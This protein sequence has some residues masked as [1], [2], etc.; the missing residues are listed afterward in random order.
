MTV[1]NRKRYYQPSQVRRLSQEWKEARKKKD[2]SEVERLKKAI[3]TEYIQ[4]GEIHKMGEKPDDDLAEW[5][6]QKALDI[7]PG[8]PIANY[9]LA[10]LMFKKEYYAEA[11]F[12]FE[13]ALSSFSD[14]RL[15]NTQ[16]IIAN[17]FMSCAAIEV[18]RQSSREYNDLRDDADLQYEEDRITHFSQKL[19][20]PSE[21]MVEH[22][23]YRH[24]TPSVNELVS[25]ARYDQA[26]DNAVAGGEVV[27]L[28][29]D[30]DGYKM[31]YRAYEG[32]SLESTQFI[33]L[34]SIL[35]SKEYVTNEKLAKCLNEYDGG[36]QKEDTIRRN[37][38][39]LNNR[40]PFMEKIIGT[41]Q[42][43]R[44]TGRML[45]E[46]ISYCILCRASDVLPDE[47]YVT[48]VYVRNHHWGITTKQKVV[49]DAQSAINK[50]SYVWEVTET[51]A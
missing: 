38:N 40:I 35:K 25:K 6:M 17:M 3:V 43:G 13:K 51:F 41:G 39:R 14:K 46:G 26:F 19:D 47:M 23:Y 21:N 50:A 34:Y 36:E 31:Y 5:H 7:D 9:R 32:K 48:I 27:V 18:A 15:Q 28:V 37:L 16:Q 29:R 12:Y 20:V 22:M 33:M 24:V 44:R 1:S 30:D 49:L 4:A 45:K 8:H 42:V 10:H 2:Q 11:I